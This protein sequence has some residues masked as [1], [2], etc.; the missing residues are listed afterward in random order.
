MLRVLERSPLKHGQLLRSRAGIKAWLYHDGLLDIFGLAV[1]G[2]DWHDLRCD[3][4]ILQSFSGRRAGVVSF[5]KTLV[6]AHGPDGGF[7]FVPT[8]SGHWFSSRDT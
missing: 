6:R 4:L 2:E 7:V 8:A 1:Q 3:A 5:S